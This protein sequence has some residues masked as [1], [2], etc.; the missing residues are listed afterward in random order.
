MSTHYHNSIRPQRGFTL[1]IAIILASVAL[2]VG[3]S[4]ADI[5]YKQI[6]LSSAAR[7]SQVAF[8]RADSAMECALYYDQKF[9]AF[10]V[11][12]I[13]DQGAMQC[14]GRA[15]TGYAEST[16]TGGGVRT[17]FDVACAGTGRSAT[18]AVYKEGTGTCSASGAKSCIFASG[19]NTCSATDPSLFE[20]GLKI[21]Y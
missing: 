4:L 3:L 16:L 18:V 15:V 13:F 1:L 5:A 11:G 2:V 9:A 20:R 10:N 12:N 8:Y 19:F 17:T 7:N 21:F 6:V 14:D